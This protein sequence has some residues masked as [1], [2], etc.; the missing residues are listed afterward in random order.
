[1]VKII[2]EN[3]GQKVLTGADLNKSALQ[4]FHAHYVDWMHAVAKGA[5]P[6]VK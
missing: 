5:A 3:L 2:I 4:H 6:H 1:M